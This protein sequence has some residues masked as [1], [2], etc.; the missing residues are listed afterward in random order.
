MN[1][2]NSLVINE[3]ETF[4]EKIL[5]EIEAFRAIVCH[6]INNLNSNQFSFDLDN[7]IYK[8]KYEYE[9]SKLKLEE[10]AVANTEK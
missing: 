9:Q 4:M 3:V 6:N 1:S 8:I 7:L 2:T 10:T 5:D